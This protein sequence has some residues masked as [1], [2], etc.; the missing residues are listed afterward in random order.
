MPG[1][2]LPTVPS[3]PNLSWHHKTS[4]GLMGDKPLVA[5]PSRF[6]PAGR[7]TQVSASDS[8][9]LIKSSELSRLSGWRQ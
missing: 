9:R 8:L 7:N 3:G 4:F 5:T 1:R 6:E 2:F